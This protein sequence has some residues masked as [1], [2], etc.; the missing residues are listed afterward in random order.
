[1]VSS[2]R[3]RR[4]HTPR[5]LLPWT[6]DGVENTAKHHDTACYPEHA[7]P[8]FDRYLSITTQ[9]QLSHVNEDSTHKDKDKDK[10][11]KL[12]LKETGAVD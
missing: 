12:V 6:K 11:L 3:R 2:H 5:L 10:G 1:M 4:C 9:R 8:R 7:S